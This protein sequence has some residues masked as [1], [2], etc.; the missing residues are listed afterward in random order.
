[1]RFERKKK[2]FEYNLEYNKMEESPL[3]NLAWPLIK[4]YSPGK[5]KKE[6]GGTFSF[7][8]K[9]NSPLRFK[10]TN[11]EVSFKKLSPREIDSYLQLPP[12]I[13]Q[14]TKRLA[15]SLKGE[16]PQKTILNTMEFYKTN[17]FH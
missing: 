5:L 16:T 13:G 7:R 14:K 9:R 10:A 8:P 6:S 3:F 4:Q 15:K 2:L 12:T 1:M 11:Y 17:L